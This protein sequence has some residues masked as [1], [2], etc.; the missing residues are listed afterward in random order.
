MHT[1]LVDSMHTSSRY[2]QYILTIHRVIVILLLESSI[3]SLHTVALYYA[4]QLVCILCMLQTLIATSQY[5][6]VCTHV[7]CLAG[8]WH[9][10][11]THDTIFLYRIHTHCTCQ[12]VLCI[13][14]PLHILRTRIYSSTVLMLCI[15]C[16]PAGVHVQE[17]VCMHVV[18][19]SYTSLVIYSRILI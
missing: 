16:T 13:Q 15:H 9:L 11:A 2:G 19:E 10:P 14:L 3:H 17:Y 12:V 18:N 8:A 4:Y 7:R 1:L 6:H 5:I